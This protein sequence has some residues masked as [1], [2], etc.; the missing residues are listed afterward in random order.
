MSVRVTL[1][2]C[3]SVRHITQFNKMHS[4]HEG[5]KL[6]VLKPQPGTCMAFINI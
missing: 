4:H 2:E 1:G 3:H 6:A 5:I